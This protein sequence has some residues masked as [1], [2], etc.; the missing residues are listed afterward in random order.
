MPNC[1]TQCWLC[2]LP[3]RFDTYKGC[4]HYC[5]YCFVT[6]A[7]KVDLSEIKP[8]ESVA[9]LKKFIAGGRNAECSW[10]DW[11][12]PL[13]WGGMS[14]PFQPVEHTYRRSLDCLKVFAETKYPFVVST[15]GVIPA[16]PEYLKL[17]SECNCCFQVSALGSTYDRIE[18]GAPSF[19]ERMAMLKQVS[20]VVQRSIVRIQPFMHEMLQE[21]CGN[22]AAYKE[23]GAYGVTV[24]GMKFFESRPGLVKIANDMSYPYDVIR[25]DFL[26]LRKAAHDAGLKIYAGE[27][28]L[29]A[30][31]DSLTCCGTDGMPGFRANEFNLNHILNGE[32]PKPTPQMLKPRTGTP[33]RATVQDTLRGR[34]LTAQS[35]AFNMAEYYQK[36]QAMVDEVLGL[37][38][39]HK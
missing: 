4:S 22:M 18:P 36:N 19:T 27:N 10:A 38:K 26:A 37:G 32:R 28:R 39:V 13:H 33:F 9:S 2:D 16:E 31:G 24:E 20:P 3:I 25:S 29:R 7:H 17:L 34:Y 14:D 11:D 35:F 1:G 21:V 8:A 12:I 6:R 30:M 15:K 5:A 23:A